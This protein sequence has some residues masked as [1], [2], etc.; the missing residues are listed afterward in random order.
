MIKLTKLN[1]DEF[2][3]NAEL[4]RFVERRPD[5]YVTLTTDDR[6]IVRESL[7][8]VVSRSLAYSRAVRFPPA[9]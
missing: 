7:E 2:V 3:V 4:I 6:F 5:T 9:A 8:E 1:G